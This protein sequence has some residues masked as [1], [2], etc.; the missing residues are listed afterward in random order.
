MHYMQLP[1]FLLA[2][3]WELAKI[4]VVASINKTVE[5]ILYNKI[6]VGNEAIILQ[7]KYIG[8]NQPYFFGRPKRQW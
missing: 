1:I 4:W 7:H 2:K 8:K 3:K 5:R 6:I